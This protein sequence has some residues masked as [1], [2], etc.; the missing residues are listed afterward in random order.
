MR[1]AT[2][3]RLQVYLHT[4]PPV[5]ACQPNIDLIGLLVLHANALQRGRACRMLRIDCSGKTRLALPAPKLIMN[6]HA[7]KNVIIRVCRCALGS[8]KNTLQ[9][10]FSM[11]SMDVAIDLVSFCCR[12]QGAKYICNPMS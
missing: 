7:S 9:H 10:N 8:W 12:C 11:H 3:V 1:L 2:H 5:G 4:H 6:G